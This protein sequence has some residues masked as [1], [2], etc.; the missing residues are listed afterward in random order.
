MIVFLHVAIVALIALAVLL[1]LMPYLA[2]Q[3]PSLDDRP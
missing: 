1:L 2:F 3:D